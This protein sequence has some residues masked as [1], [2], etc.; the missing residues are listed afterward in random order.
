VLFSLEKYSARFILPLVKKTREQTQTVIVSGLSGAGMSS[1]LKALEDLGFE[2][3]DNFPLSLVRPLINDKQTPARPIAIGLDTRTRGFNVKDVF[4]TANEIDADLLFVTCDADVLQRRYTETRRRHPMAGH[5]RVKT[6][7]Q[8]EQDL[9]AP[10]QAEADFLIDTT[11]LSI[12]DLKHLMRG[13]FKIPADSTLNITLM[14][15]GFKHGAPRNIDIIMDVR[16]LKNPHWDKALKPLTGKDQA[17]ADYVSLDTAFEPFI[18]HFKAML[19]TLLPRYGAEGKSYL[20]IAIGC[21]GGR[22]RSVFTVEYLKDWLKKNRFDPHVE[23]RD[24]V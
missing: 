23:H 2:V 5:G 21:T 3:F 12:H 17:I 24:L 19:E 18:T 20:T 1:V 22:H 6:G 16:F 13:Y 11:H 10:L 14:S 4:R 7:I 8:M 9:L 15:F